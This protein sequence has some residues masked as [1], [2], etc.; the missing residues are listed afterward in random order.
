MVAE[1]VEKEHRHVLD[2]IR[3]LTAENSA[4]KLAG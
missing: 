1:N 4:A 3:N 2:A